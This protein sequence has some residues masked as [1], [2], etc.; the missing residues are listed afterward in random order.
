MPANEA[1]TDR[2]VDSDT[3][4]VGHGIQQQNL[5]VEQ[6]FDWVAHKIGSIETLAV[7]TN[8]RVQRIEAAIYGNGHPGL[9]EKALVN[10]WLSILA[11]IGALLALVR[12]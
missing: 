9:I 8:E 1:S 6:G 11:C 4:A 10:R 7:D 2:I 5:T 3:V 12:S